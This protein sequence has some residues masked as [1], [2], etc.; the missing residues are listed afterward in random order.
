MHGAGDV[1]VAQDVAQLLG[2]VDELDAV[3]VGL[4]DNLAAGDRL[5]GSAGSP[6]GKVSVMMVIIQH[7]CVL[8]WTALPLLLLDGDLLAWHGLGWVQDDFANVEPRALRRRYGRAGG[9]RNTQ[10][11]SENGFARH[12]TP[13]LCKIM[14]LHKTVPCR[15]SRSEGRTSWHPRR[16]SPRGQQPCSGRACG[17][18]Q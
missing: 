7:M 17:R 3:K 1:D 15:S 10:C 5:G 13:L 14:A 11:V 12:G 18:R 8:L 6:D 16:G 9:A 2:L 4:V